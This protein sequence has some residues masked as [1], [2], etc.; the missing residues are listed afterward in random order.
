MRKKQK[1]FFNKKNKGF[2]VAE[3]LVVI[4][5][6]TL[7]SSVVLVATKEARNRARITRGLQFSASINHALGDRAV[8]LWGFDE[9]Q[10]N[11][12]PADEP[13]NDI[14]D[15][16]G[17]EHHGT[18]VHSS[19]PI[20]WTSDTPSGKGYSL[21]AIGVYSN[22]KIPYSEDFNID[23]EGRTYEAWI[24]G[25]SFSAWYNVF[26]GFSNFYLPCFYVSRDE[27][28]L[29]FRIISNLSAKTISGKTG[30]GVKK[31]HHAVA[32]YDGEGYVRI[33]LDGVLDS[34]VEGPYL[35]PDSTTASYFYIGRWYIYYYRFNG[36]IDEVR[37]YKGALSSAQIQKHYVEGA[38]KRGLLVEK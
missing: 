1:P 28:Y 11:T 7:L 20:S 21:S 32:T 4:A 33:Y 13:Y 38:K 29:R 30:L 26:M 31:W 6:I 9:N 16:S 2:T 25:E 18:E 12:C 22:V 35:N 17:N 8:G 37:I 10:F 14:C 15:S 5:I 19:F 23:Q 36:L 24:K 34:D 3:I 27:N